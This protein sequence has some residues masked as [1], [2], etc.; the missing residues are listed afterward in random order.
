[1]WLLRVIVSLLLFPALAYVL[2]WMLRHS[3]SLYGQA[4]RSGQE[5]TYRFAVQNNEGV[6]LRPSGGVEIS[7]QITNDGKF[8]GTPRA[9]VGPKKISIAQTEKRIIIPAQEIPAYDTWLVECTTTPDARQLR[10][11][12]A[13]A[14]SRKIRRLWHDL[15]RHLVLR[16]SKIADIEGAHRTPSWGLYLSATIFGIGLYASTTLVEL[17][18]TNFPISDWEIWIDLVAVVWIAGVAAVILWMVQREPAPVI[19]GYWEEAWLPPRATTESPA[20]EAR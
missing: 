18:S 4:T 1:M 20:A 5:N 3:L 6:A 15:P 12:V 8:L 14:N 17:M 10:L 9:Y 7:I 11:S 16:A 2:R 19:Q 13:D